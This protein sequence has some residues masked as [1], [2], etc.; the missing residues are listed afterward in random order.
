MKAFGMGKIMVY[1]AVF[2][3]FA[4]AFALPQLASSQT[5]LPTVIILPDGSVSPS[6]APIQQNGNIYTFT[7]NLN[8]ALKIQKSNI[9]LDGA[10]CTLTGSFSGNSTD[11]WVVGTGPDPNSSDYYTIGVDLGGESVNGITV[12]NL[13]VENF[14]IGM[15]IWT[16]NNTVTGNHMSGNIVGLLMSGS[17]G[18]ITKNVIS[19]NIDGLFFGSNS[20]SGETPPD[21]IVHQNSFENNSVQ[22]S[23]CQCKTYNLTETPHFWDDGRAGNFWSDYNGTDSNGDGIGDSAYVIDPLDQDR[24][25]LMQSPIQTQVPAKFPV[26]AVVLGVSAALVAA[27]A[28]VILYRRRKPNA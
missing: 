11:I 15:Y 4:L 27:A 20:A 22:I 5:T 17:N 2:L 18:T 19:D 16:Q 24:Y 26:E 23:G 8:A 21:M 25:P 6:T 28:A 7:G 10:G 3:V 12:E 9:V 14:S 1:A 13:K